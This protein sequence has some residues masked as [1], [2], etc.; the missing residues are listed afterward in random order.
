MQPWILYVV[1]S[2]LITVQ[3]VVDRITWQ[4]VTELWWEAWFV[5][6]ATGARCWGKIELPLGRAP[7]MTQ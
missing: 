2:K 6:Y 3:Q 1:N 7:M 5:M 4:H